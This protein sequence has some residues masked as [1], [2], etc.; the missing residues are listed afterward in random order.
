MMMSSLCKAA[1]EEARRGRGRHNTLQF[2]VLKYDNLQQQKDLKMTD[3]C[4][5]KFAAMSE[6]IKSILIEKALN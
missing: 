6:I 4:C 3:F 5:D 1:M 2:A